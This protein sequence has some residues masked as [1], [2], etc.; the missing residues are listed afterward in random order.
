[1]AHFLDQGKI[2]AQE[3]ISADKAGMLKEAATLYDASAELI[4]LGL[5][6]EFNEGVQAQL[7]QKVGAYK[8]RSKALLVSYEI[9]RGEKRER[10]LRNISMSKGSQPDAKS[11]LPRTQTE[12]ETNTVTKT[13]TPLKL[14]EGD[15]S[16]KEK[17]TMDKARR[18]GERGEPKVNGLEKEVDRLRRL[19]GLQ[20]EIVE[21]T[22]AE[23]HRLRGI[24]D[25]QHSTI[26]ALSRGREIT[27]DAY[28]SGIVPSSSSTP[29]GRGSTSSSISHQSK[30]VSPFKVWA[31]YEPPSE[32]KRSA[33]TKAKPKKKKA[34]SKSRSKS[35]Y[36]P[37]TS[38]FVNPA[39]WNQSVAGEIPDIFEAEALPDQE[40]IA[41]I[42]R[43]M[44]R[45]KTLF[46]EARAQDRD[47][48]Q[49]AAERS[50]RSPGP[51]RVRICLACNHHGDMPSPPSEA[52]KRLKSALKTKTKAKA[53]KS[54]S[55]S[56]AKTTQNSAKGLASSP[57]RFKFNRGAQL[58]SEAEGILAQINA[59]LYPPKKPYNTPSRLSVSAEER[60]VDGELDLSLM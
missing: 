18:G 16:S 32:A 7:L 14:E 58:A 23:M 56:P 8:E 34:R 1:M 49:R 30:G 28:I 41:Y 20:E 26:R 46:S 31:S 19:C 12:T 60:L 39:A 59:T 13:E 4:N 5:L 2:C 43:S 44:T 3:A 22:K 29:G 55:R 57:T 48:M 9:L 24:V 42:N 50:S 11:H 36:L 35:P 51:G 52:P 33:I 45:E 6:S 37:D 40:N 47:M 21:E 15:R 25:G 38:S 17:I 10:A 53:R 54:A 27:R